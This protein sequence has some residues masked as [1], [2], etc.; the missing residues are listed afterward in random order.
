[1]AP[2][3]GPNC[4]MLGGEPESF[5]SAV[6]EPFVRCDGEDGEA[7]FSVSVSPCFTIQITHSVKVRLQSTRYQIE[8]KADPAL[9]FQACN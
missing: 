3:H 7:A 6:L 8:F 1:M 4:L 2:S 9:T 5:G